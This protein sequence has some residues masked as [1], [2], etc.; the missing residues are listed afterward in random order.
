MGLVSLSSASQ[1]H[2]PPIPSER[3]NA[4]VSRGSERMEFIR[5]YQ[6]R[7]HIADQ[8]VEQALAFV[9]SGH[10][11]IENRTDV[12]TC[13]VGY[14]PH[15]C[16]FHHQFED[17]GG[18]VQVSVVGI[19]PR[20]RLRER[21]FAGSA[22]PALYVLL[23]KVPKALAGIVVT[24]CAG[25]IGLVFLAGQADN[26]FASAL[27]LVPRAEHSRLSVSADGG[28]FYAESGVTGGPRTHNRRITNPAL[29]L[30]SY[31]HRGG[32][33]GLAPLNAL[34]LCNLWW[35]SHSV[36]T[37][38][39]FAWI[40]L[41]NSF[42]TSVVIQSSTGIRNRFFN[43]AG[44]KTVHTG[45]WQCWGLVGSSDLDFFCGKLRN[46]RSCQ[47][48]LQFFLGKVFSENTPVQAEHTSPCFPL[49][50][51]LRVSCSVDS[52][53]INRMRLC[54]LREKSLQGGRDRCQ[55]VGLVLAKIESTVNQAVSYLRDGKPLLG[56]AVDSFTNRIGKT[57]LAFLV[58]LRPF[59]EITEVFQSL[60]VCEHVDCRKDE[61]N[62]LFFLGLKIQLL[63]LKF[64]V[65]RHRSVENRAIFIGGHNRHDYRLVYS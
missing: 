45:L 19:Q 57:F 28:A 4:T 48:S 5:L 42:L 12:Q 3:R 17:T 33:Q 43:G 41:L 64:R 30:L 7:A 46:R 62:G 44:S 29:C 32:I 14:R 13:K 35:S 16:A 37:G 11:Q 23:T 9:S 38:S 10:H 26:D 39:P 8:R 1:V 25:H 34:A 49:S 63:L 56:C 51:C 31:R 6:I 65:S 27:R 55:R 36:H 22:A 60:I 53:T 40:E 18:G 59:L 52:D 58:A 50:G 15:R 2:T 20:N 61:L 54:V 47:E 24:T 21:S